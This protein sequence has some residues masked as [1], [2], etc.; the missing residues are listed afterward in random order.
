MSVCFFL[1][2]NDKDGKGK[3]E[4]K[5]LTDGA[6]LEG[7]VDRQLRVEERLERVRHAAEH[8]GHEQRAGAVVEDAADVAR[9]L[10]EGRVV[11]ELV[12]RL[13]KQL[14]G[15]V[16]GRAVWCA[17][18]GKRPG[19]S[20]VGL[21]GEDLRTPPSARQERLVACRRRPSSAIGTPRDSLG[22]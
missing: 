21:R 2:G 14:G 19:V 9:R 11:D 4:H 22:A 3:H 13:V 16:K 6:L 17:G 10:A 20:N 15:L 12:C 7:V 1:R 5:R 8:L 18:Q